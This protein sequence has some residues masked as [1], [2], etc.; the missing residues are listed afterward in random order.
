MKEIQVV[1]VL[2]FIIVGD[3]VVFGSMEWKCVCVVINLMGF[4]SIYLPRDLIRF[5]LRPTPSMKKGLD[6]VKL[7]RFIFVEIH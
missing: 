7:M 5:H 6:T 1:G 3:F 4:S 2:L